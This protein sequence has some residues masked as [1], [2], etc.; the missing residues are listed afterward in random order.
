MELPDIAELPPDMSRDLSRAMYPSGPYGGTVGNVVDN[1]K[2]QGYFSPSKTSGLASTETF[3][4][5]SW[6]MLRMTPDAKYLMIHMAAY[7]CGPCLSAAKQLAAKAPEM[8]PKGGLLMGVLT[9]GRTPS[10]PAT[11]SNLGSFIN[12]AKAPFTY[13]LDSVSP[14]TDLESYFDSLRDSFIIIDLSTMKI[15]NIIDNFS[16]GGGVAEAIPTFEAL[17]H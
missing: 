1:F 13:T 12:K 11:E 8:V 6:D 15:V 16:G 17:L 4:E 7:W 10:E 14:Q 2:F 5:V 3:G 9:E